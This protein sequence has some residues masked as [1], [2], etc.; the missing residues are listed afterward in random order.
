MQISY[1]LVPENATTRD[2]VFETNKKNVATVSANGLITALK[3][4]EVKITAS[5]ADSG[6]KTSLTIKVV[7]QPESITFD[8]AEYN[9]PVG[10]KKK[11]K[12]T[13]EPADANNKKVTWASSDKS[14]ASVDSTGAVKAIKPGD[15]TITATSQSD[16]S[17]VGSVTLHSVLPAKSLYFNRTEYAIPIGET[18]QLEPVVLPEE[19]T[20][21]RVKY[22]VRNPNICSVD[23]N[24]LVT[25]LHGGRTAVVATTADGSNHSVTLHIRTVVPVEEVYFHQPGFRVQAGGHAFI[26]PMVKPTGATSESM[27]WSSDNPAI[28]TVTTLGNRVRIEGKQ[29]GS[30]TITGATSNG[31]T[32]ALDVH[33]GAP[34]HALTAKKLKVQDGQAVV[35]LHNASDMHMTGATLLVKDKNGEQAVPVALNLAPG[36]TAEVSLPVSVSGKMADAAVAKWETNTGFITNA[37]VQK[38]D[39]RISRGH[40]AWTGDQN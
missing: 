37:G 28:A 21:K 24:G 12:V 26:Q 36:E 15:V 2:V 13:V 11:L 40:M 4:G 20:N 22:E 7:Q 35:T 29:W 5:N 6:I 39:Y 18:L 27:Y 8:E 30:C 14:I 16:S 23:E 38:H 10:K 25:T 17:V 3:R 34:W 9:V 1:E 19:A 32:V 33:V 31:I